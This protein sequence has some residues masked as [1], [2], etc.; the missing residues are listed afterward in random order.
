[1]ETKEK[2][3]YYIWDVL[4]DVDKRLISAAKEHTKEYRFLIYT[5]TC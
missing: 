4:D 1:M 5:S 3:D 2:L